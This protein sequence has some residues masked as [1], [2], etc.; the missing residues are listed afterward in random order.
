MRTKGRDEGEEG[1]R[2]FL[3][4]V[5][6]HP[7]DNLQGCL[8]CRLV[9]ENEKQL[10]ELKLHPGY[11]EGGKVKWIPLGMFEQYKVATSYTA[12]EQC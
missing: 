6:Q 3:V 12:R 5:T 2:L 4:Q 8:L 9:P 1:A 11:V 10:L 7:L